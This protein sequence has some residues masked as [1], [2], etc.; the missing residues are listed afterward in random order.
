[1]SSP[2]RVLHYAFCCVMMVFLVGPILA[3]VPISFSSSGF[4]SYPIPGLSLQ[5]YEKV[6]AASGPWLP[7]LRNSLIVGTGAMALA[8]LLG[9]L[10]AL[11]LARN[12]LPGRSFL[13]GLLIAPMV[14]P[15][16]ISGVAMY[17]LFARIGLTASYLGL[18][19]AHAALGAPFVVITVTA[20]LRNFDTTLVRAAYSLGASPV[21]A[22]FTVTLPLILPGVLS[23]GLFAFIFSFDEVVVAL[24]IGGPEQRTLPRQMFDGIRDT[25][26]PSILA[27]STL[28]V[29]VT[30]AFMVL[31]ARLGRGTGSKPGSNA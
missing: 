21:H 1:M 28:L 8:T 3:V 18:I 27:M 29:G 10:A 16:V 30:V 5:W 25:I 13:L 11:G 14:V 7:A 19:L 24:F 12:D 4:L 22:F 2:T 23:G 9:T 26:D 31:L 15:V 17:F 6:L 20:T